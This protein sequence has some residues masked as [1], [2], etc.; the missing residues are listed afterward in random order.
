MGRAEVLRKLYLSNVTS[1]LWFSFLSQFCKGRGFGVGGGGGEGE[2][3]YAESITEVNMHR[4]IA[5]TSHNFSLSLPL[6]GFT[7]VMH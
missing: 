3:S 1:L 2:Y 6:H 5:A 7:L 4:Y